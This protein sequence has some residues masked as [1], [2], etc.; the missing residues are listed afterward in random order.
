VMRLGTQSFAVAAGDTV[1]IAPGTPHRVTNT[2]IE[3]LKILCA[4]APAYSHDDTFLL[5]E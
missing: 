3:P 1:A 4:C 5:D 2:G